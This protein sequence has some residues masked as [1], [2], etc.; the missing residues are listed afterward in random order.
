MSLRFVLHASA[1]LAVVQRWGHFVAFSLCCAIL[2]VV[3][4]LCLS[5]YLIYS[6]YYCRQQALKIPNTL[7]IQ[8]DR[9]LWYQN[10]RCYIATNSYIRPRLCVLHIYWEADIQEA[11][12]FWRKPK[13]I[14]ETEVKQLRWHYRDLYC[15]LKDSLYPR[16]GYRHYYL[17]LLPDMFQQSE[18]FSALYSFLYVQLQ[19]TH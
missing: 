19:P 3:W 18:D 5:P 14:P 17:I 1:Q 6:Y 15:W 10:Q 13:T 8:A 9:W 16:L 11:P 12:W 7:I 2:P 4:S